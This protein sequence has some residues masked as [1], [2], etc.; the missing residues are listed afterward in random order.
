MDEK[1]FYK[2]KDNLKFRVNLDTSSLK[3]HIDGIKNVK[4]EIATL[5][6]LESTI[7]SFDE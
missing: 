6:G 4:F 2:I 5:R 1:F 7:P 3:E